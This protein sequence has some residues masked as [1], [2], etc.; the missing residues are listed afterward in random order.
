M[1]F[2]K[3]RLSDEKIFD[4]YRQLPDSTTDEG[5]ALAGGR[6]IRDAQ[7]KACEEEAER[8]FRTLGSE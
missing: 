3:T 6:A 5:M 4:I 2:S 8:Q 1:D 7:L